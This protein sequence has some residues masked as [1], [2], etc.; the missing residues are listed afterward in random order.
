MLDEQEGSDSFFAVSLDD[1]WSVVVA[2]VGGVVSGVCGRTSK[3]AE[4]EARKS[5]PDVSVLW[6]L[7]TNPPVAGWGLLISGSSSSAR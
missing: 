5:S 6:G 1:C 4:I 3:L 7:F 2:G